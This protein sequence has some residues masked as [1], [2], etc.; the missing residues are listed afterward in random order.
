MSYQS[1]KPILLTFHDHFQSMNVRAH[2]IFK[3]RVQGVWFRA[4]TQKKAKELGLTGWVR[5]LEDGS[6]ESVIEGPHHLVD[7]MIHW[8]SNEQPFASVAEVEE[9]EEEFTGDFKGFDII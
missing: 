7:E 6:V 1:F 2:V 3:G 4:N 8:C 5:N 9:I